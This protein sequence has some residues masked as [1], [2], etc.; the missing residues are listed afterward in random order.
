[1][2]NHLFNH[3]IFQQNSKLDR[4]ILVIL[5]SIFI[6][7]PLIV[8]LHVTDFASPLISRS[9]LNSGTKG[10]FYSYYK[11]LYLIGATCLICFLFVFRMAF[12]SY[13]VKE[14]YINI[15]VAILFV[16][17]GLSAALAPY[18]SLA[19]FGEYNRLD[20][21]L[22]Y[23]ACIIL[24]FIAANLKYTDRYVSAFIY[25]LYPFTILNGIIGIMTF[26]GADLLQVDFIHTL[27]F[28]KEFSDLNVTEGSSFQS[29]INHPNY[30]SGISAMLI[31][32]FLTLAMF[33]LK[34]VRAIIHFCM[35]VISTMLLFTSMST[36]GFLTIVVLLPLLFL[37]LFFQ[38]KKKQGMA[39]AVSFL[40][41]LV[42]LLV[43]MSMHNDRVWD[44]SVG[45]FVSTNPFNGESVSFVTT[46]YAETTEEEEPKKVEIPPLPVLP[47][48]GFAPGTG[49][50]YIWEK[51]LEL[52]KEKPFIGYGLDT[53]SYQFPQNDVGIISGLESSDI[54]VDKPHNLYIGLAF[55]SGVFALLAFIV[56]LLVH[57]WKN[58]R[59]L[60]KLQLDS[61]ASVL[62]MTLFMG[63]MAYLIQALFNDSI[64]GTSPIFF[65]LF[66]VGVS[67]L[68]Q[69][70]EKSNQVD[71]DYES[72]FTIAGTNE[73]DQSHA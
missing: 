37:F 19:L 71:E 66:G 45:F 72:L 16:I 65:I 34:R 53:L 54:V 1:M 52:V 9:I 48:S 24:F 55:G 25:A 6:I 60:W 39:V 59:V 42:A 15:P 56:L 69:Y 38:E 43:S 67:Y 58:S 11:F 35:A 70:I 3:D 49:R 47:E 32:T 4:V 51:T 46:V 21:T 29:T 20:G 2:N 63:W 62:L 13:P 28:P 14:S 33:D 31:M 10:D 61:T 44:N 73:N 23:I 7:V 36:S 40:V 5:L 18:K 30:V 17:I 50:L 64:I 41:C 68:Q 57:F 22:T 26:F 12:W 27:I 8:R